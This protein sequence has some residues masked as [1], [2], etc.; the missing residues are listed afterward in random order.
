MHSEGLTLRAETAPEREHDKETTSPNAGIRHGETRDGPQVQQ[1]RG[2][3]PSYQVAPARWLRDSVQHGACGFRMVQRI[4]A[5]PNRTRREDH[6][7]TGAPR[8]GHREASQ[9]V[10]PLRHG[11]TLRC[12]SVRMSYRPDLHMV[13]DMETLL[14]EVSA[15]TRIAFPSEARLPPSLASGHLQDNIGVLN[16]A[17]VPTCRKS[18]GSEVR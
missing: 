2:G 12:E 3:A 4:S 16:G 15:R 17:S 9:G 5:P 7:R 14:S 11:A 13:V 8:S 6:G 1:Q 10:S 18:V